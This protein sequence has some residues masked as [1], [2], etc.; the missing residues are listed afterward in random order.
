MLTV[1][2]ARVEVE[3]WP[4]TRD[5]LLREKISLLAQAVVKIGGIM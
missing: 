1:P 4:D 5:R 2:P 3:A